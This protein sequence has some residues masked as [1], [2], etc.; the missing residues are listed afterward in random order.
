MWDL[1]APDSWLLLAPGRT[2]SLEVETDPGQGM[3]SP[4]WLPSRVIMR[5]KLIRTLGSCEAPDRK[6]AQ[7][8]AGVGPPTPFHAIKYVCSMLTRVQVCMCGRLLGNPEA[9]PSPARASGIFFIVS[10]TP[11]E[12]SEAPIQLHHSL[13]LPWPA[14][15]SSGG[16]P[17]HHTLWLLPAFK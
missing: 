4:L 11:R 2:G 9:L 13:Q 12:A 17:A 16:F 10:P 5:I 1:R 15:D 8:V 6:R 3:R 7:P 14:V